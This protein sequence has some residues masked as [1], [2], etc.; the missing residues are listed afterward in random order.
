MLEAL[1]TVSQR[2]LLIEVPEEPGIF[3][4]G[5]KHAFVAVAN[6]GAAFVIDIG[7]EHG[8]E[9]RSQL[10]FRG[11]NG[12][13]LL[14]IAHDGD[15]HFFGERK[16][17]ALEIAQQYGWPLGEVQHRFNQPFVFAP[18]RSGNGASGLVESFADRVTALGNV[19]NHLCA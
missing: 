13:V 4:A 11:F 8:E 3:K 5:T 1:D 7:V 6:D 15:E 10:A 16:I 14:M 12:E 2:R 18:A 17:L 19:D 9:M